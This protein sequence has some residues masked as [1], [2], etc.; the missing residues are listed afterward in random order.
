MELEE[1]A[2]LL[3]QHPNIDDDAYDRAAAAICLATLDTAE[4]MPP[5][6]RNKLERAA[7]AFVASAMPAQR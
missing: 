6:L 7:A 4:P 2:R 3:A 5:S 1:L